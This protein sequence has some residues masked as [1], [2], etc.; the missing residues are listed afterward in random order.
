M[1]IEHEI[2]EAS[3]E[4]FG[5]VSFLRGYG[6]FQ[7]LFDSIPRRERL[8]QTV[9]GGE[10]ITVCMDERLIGSPALSPETTNYARMAGEGILNPN[11]AKDL[12]KAGVSGI[13]VHP[14]C[15]AKGIYAEG[16]EGHPDHIGIAAVH[17]LA[18]ETGIAV[19]GVISPDKFRVPFHDARVAYYDGT[20]RFDWSRIAGC[21]LPPGFIVS[22]AIISDSSY[23]QTEVDVAIGIA[24]S[25]HGFGYRFTEKSPF[26]LVGI[27]DN[28][29]GS[30][31]ADILQRELQ[32]VSQK[33]SAVA[34]D[35]IIA[36]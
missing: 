6:S 5:G 22:R 9:V 27:T 7:A 29:P 19:V 21:A 8:L 28:Q 36:R 3:W 24:Q 16:K 32:E 14:E 34:V 18:A 1:K 20:G 35:L 30:I 25:H 26:Y 17:D 10:L 13:L 15:G 31:K 12:K 11:A 33:R 23:A 2:I 4:S